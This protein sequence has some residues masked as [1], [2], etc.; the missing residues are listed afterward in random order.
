MQKTDRW[1]AMRV[2]SLYALFGG[3]WI[4]VSDRLLA[5]WLLDTKMLTRWQSYK[6]WAFVLFSAILIYLLVSKTLQWISSTRL[7]L[8]KVLDSVT[9]AFLV[10]DRDWRITFINPEAARINK[11]PPAAFLG[12]THWEEW[13]ASV[14]TVVEEQ[15]RKAMNERVVVH[16]EHHYYVAGEY[17]TWLDI[18]AYPYEDGLALLYR[19]I[20]DAVRSR[21][22]LQQQALELQ[23]LHA[24]AQQRAG[25]LA[26]LYEQKRDLA[27]QL[28]Q[29]VAERTRELE[30]AMQRAASADHLKS[31]FLASMSHELR[32]PLN[33]IIGFTG[34][35]LAE[36]AGPLNPEQS[37][38]LGWVQDSSRHLLALINDVLDISRIEAGQLE[39]RLAP[40]EMHTAIERCIRLVSESAQKKGVLLSVSIDSRIGTPLSD[41]RRVEQILINLL[42][43]AIKFTP[44]GEI[45]LFCRPSDGF[46]VTSVQDTGIGIRSED[47]EKLFL[48]FRQIDSGLDR[49]HEGTGLGLS[50]C[51]RLVEAL[52]GKICV[53]SVW[54]KGSTFTF[55]L[56]T[57]AQGST[58]AN[59][60]DH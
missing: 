45:R 44:R 41:Q 33:S 55:T 49:R 35:L 47:I 11:K 29:R 17:D 24:E 1:L 23:T 15:Y 14:G 32:T 60:T 6:G 13:P 59:D 40:F 37:K 4:L 51:K 10:M 48:P 9:D 16:F 26:I 20:T 58:H 56:P 54:E 19:D 52:G 2:A 8:K 22:S 46:V 53:E 21:Q 27:E 5:R 12:K 25:E 42:N 50:I 7:Y 38:Q 3:L 30:L 36:L 34:I 28:E 39:V 31:A 18:R 57:T 43:N